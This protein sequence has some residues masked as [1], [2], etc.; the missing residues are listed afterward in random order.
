ECGF[1]EIHGG[2]VIGSAYRC[3]GERLEVRLNGA[4][5]DSSLAVDIGDTHGR[6][7]GWRAGAEASIAARNRLQSAESRSD[8][9]AHRGSRYWFALGVPYHHS[10]QILELELFTSQLPVAAQDAELRISG[11]TACPT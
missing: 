8:R 9:K 2:A 7:I 1:D 6:L 10:Q 11:V 5:T 4:H 3:C